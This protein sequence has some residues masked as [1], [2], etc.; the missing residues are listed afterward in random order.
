MKGGAWGFVH[1]FNM[2]KCWSEPCSRGGLQ[3]LDG[4]AHVPNPAEHNLGYKQLLTGSGDEGRSGDV[5]QGG[6]LAI[7]M[8]VGARNCKHD[9][10][11]SQ[12]HEGVWTN[13]PVC[14]G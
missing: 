9:D 5:M 7:P 13:V 6:Y 2:D 14:I 8:L 11:S 4:H 3:P 10:R 12:M 1:R